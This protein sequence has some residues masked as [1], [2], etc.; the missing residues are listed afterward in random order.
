MAF[1]FDVDEDGIYGGATDLFTFE[2]F[3]LRN[4][5]SNNYATKSF[6]VAVKTASNPN[7]TYIKVPGTSAGIPNYN[8]AQIQQ[9]GVLVAIDGEHNSTNWAAKNIQD[10]DV[11]SIWL[12]QNDQ[13]NTLD[14]QFDANFDG[15]VAGVDDAFTLQSFHL[16]NY[17]ENDRAIKYFQVEVKTT[18]SPSWSKIP[19]FGSQAGEPDYPFSLAANGGSLSYIDDQMN[20]SN[21]AASNLIVRN[22][23]YDIHHGKKY[24]RLR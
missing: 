1:Q 14:F 13:S 4:F 7:W 18:S 10:D 8:F 12:A 24:R 16:I 20:A 23:F 11:N 22:Q 3:F 17:G 21:Y 6:Q 15:V 5:S 19:V 2:R 9:G